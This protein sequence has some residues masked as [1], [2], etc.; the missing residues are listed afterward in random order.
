MKLVTYTT[1][2]SN[3][4]LSTTETRTP[5]LGIVQDD[6]IIDVE[7]LGHKSN[8]T[9]PASMLE[10]IDAGLSEVEKLSETIKNANENIIASCSIPINEVTLLA[11]IP[12]PRK[13][14][15]GIGLNYTE[16]VHWIRQMNCRKSR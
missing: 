5:K 10:L 1:K 11:P 13:N 14:I 8:E 15:I 12:K 2:N 16:H 3:S 9:F 7:L 6:T 4:S